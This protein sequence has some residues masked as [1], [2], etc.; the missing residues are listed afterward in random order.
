MTQQQ[1]FAGLSTLME[2]L[3]EQQQT[4]ELANLQHSLFRTCDEIDGMLWELH[5]ANA[6]EIEAA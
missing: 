3:R 4:T 1:I 5:P 2:T 6:P